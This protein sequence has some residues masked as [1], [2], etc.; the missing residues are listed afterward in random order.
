[1]T[2]K[3]VLSALAIGAVALV[4]A[5]CGG[6]GDDSTTSGAGSTPA[7]TGAT[8]TPATSTGAAGGGD[9]LDGGFPAK[10]TPVKGGRL[11]IA[12]DSNID[13]WNGLSYYGISWSY[14]YFMARGLYGYP[15]SVEQ[16]ATDTVQ[17]EI[18]ADMPEISPDGL[19][20]TVKLREGI[21]F[22]D[23]SPV[24]AKDV[25]ATY[26]YM[27]DPNIQCATGGPPSSG[28]YNVIEG[29][30][31]YNKAMTDSKGAD[32]PGLSGITVVDDL[33]VAFKLKEVDGSFLRALAMGWG[34]IRPAATPH[35]VTDTPPPF[36]GPYHLTKYVSDKS[37]AID[38]EPTWADNVAAGMPEEADENNLDGIDADLAMPNDIATQKLKDNQLDIGDGA[39]IGSDVPQLAQDEQYK[40]RY[41]STPD[42][43]IDY[44]VFRTDK[45][46][47]DNAKLRQAV[48]FAVDR[49]Q[50]SK[51]IG[52]A[53]K[54]EPWG[55]I[56][57]SNLMAE[58]PTDT[59]P[60]T[61]DVEKA[62]ALVAESGVATPIKIELVHFAED[63]APQQAQAIKE[64]LDAVGFEV[65]LKAVSSDAFYGVL[66]DDTAPWSIGLAGWGQ[67]Y[68]DAI[69]FF[70]PLLS[71]PDGKPTGSN[72]GNFC[73]AAFD[74]KILEINKM[75]VGDE[76]TAAWAQL[77]H[78]TAVNQTPWWVMDNRRVVN[79]VS[80]R[81]GNFMYAPAKQ[82]YFGSYFIKQ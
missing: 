46:P 24:T 65:T 3:R 71:C 10:E 36:V 37:V 63:P 68:S 7:D 15:N 77:A 58:Q 43:A 47:F 9:F 31:E 6:S 42:A 5:A 48:N 79:L 70:R 34:F 50:N 18:A 38:R 78:D 69:T 64:A 8:S 20:Y 25:K 45:A 40:D 41:F 75:P 52:G 66:D 30:D 53:L 1:M 22:P 62:K 17:P 61:P 13:C 26:E 28:Y 44:G 35:K 21:K 27:V 55:E 59:F 54:R 12:Y 23:G 14:F 80:N 39:I 16:P 49:T 72:Y 67:D 51:I 57:S 11:S 73:D 33:T 32:N 2:N 29:Y 74:A 4:V 56:L 19:T 76:R 81:V 60:D 82:Y